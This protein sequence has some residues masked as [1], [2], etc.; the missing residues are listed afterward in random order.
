MATLGET[1]DTMTPE[2]DNIVRAAHQ[3]RGAGDV[4]RVDELVQTLADRMVAAVR[5][6]EARRP[7]RQPLMAGLR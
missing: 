7:S 2:W 3:V 1:F 5:G 4:D 6:P